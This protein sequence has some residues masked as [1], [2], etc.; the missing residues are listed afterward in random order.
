LGKN[1][2]YLR[3]GVK[4]SGVEMFAVRALEGLVQ[5]ERVVEKMRQQ[6]LSVE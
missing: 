3:R 1:Y 5:L 6:L 2:T 4:A